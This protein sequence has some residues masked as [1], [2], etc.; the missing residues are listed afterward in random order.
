MRAVPEPIPESP[1]ERVRTE[2]RRLG[3]SQRTAAQAADIS[4][5]TW[6]QFE[7]EGVVTETIRHA[8]AE[9]FD[10]PLDWVEVPVPLPPTVQQVLVQAMDDRMR[11]AVAMREESD[12][13]I[14]ALLEEI[15]A[16]L[17]DHRRLVEPDAGA[18]GV[19]D[20]LVKAV[21]TLV[22]QRRQNPGPAP[23]V[24]PRAV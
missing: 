20:R 6:S 19:L 14:I 24:E 15:L 12:R 21:D 7:K 18:D 17:R 23:Q 2:R 4:N 11:T 16:E 3:W 22:A 8:V 13:R 10:W 9:A 5:T 1:A